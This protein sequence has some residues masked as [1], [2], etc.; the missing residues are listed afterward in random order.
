VVAGKDGVMPQ[1]V[2]GTHLELAHPIRALPEEAAVFVGVELDPVAALDCFLL[3][4]F[5]GQGE[6]THR[7]SI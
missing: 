2:K 1:E 6:L 7:C 3:K 4:Y 5:L